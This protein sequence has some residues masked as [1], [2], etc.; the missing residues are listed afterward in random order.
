MRSDSWVMAWPDATGFLVA[1]PCTNSAPHP[2]VRRC[3]FL[4]KGWDTTNPESAKS[5]DRRPGSARLNRLLLER[6]GSR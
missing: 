5:Q 6:T 3:G 2:F 4:V 1:C